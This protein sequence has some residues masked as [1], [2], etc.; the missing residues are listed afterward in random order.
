MKELAIRSFS[1]SNM[2]TLISL[3]MEVL[4]HVFETERREM[5]SEQWD[6]LM[7]ENIKYYKQ[8]IDQQGHIACI[9]Y[10]NDQIIG[11]GGV[12]FYEEMPSPDNHS[13]KCA[14][15]MNIYTR[16]AH[17]KRGYAT[18]IVNWLIEQARQMGAEKIYLESTEQAK[19]MYQSVG[20]EPMH[21]YMKYNG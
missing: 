3:R 15:L 2:D 17:R 16:E 21:G 7:Q 5:S 18:Q 10:I 19:G 11:C 1:G 8:Q 12:C 6:H 4:S 9:A 14:Y 13:G 20:F